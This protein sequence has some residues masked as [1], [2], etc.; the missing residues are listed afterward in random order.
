MRR[1]QQTFKA[2]P[3]ARPHPSC[4]QQTI[5]EFEKTK[6]ANSPDVLAVEG[7]TWHGTKNRVKNLQR[8][9]H[10]HQQRIDLGVERAKRADLDE[11]QEHCKR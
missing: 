9:A 2:L 1:P 3:A 11:P 7:V 10:T 5:K 8:N 4:G 6:P